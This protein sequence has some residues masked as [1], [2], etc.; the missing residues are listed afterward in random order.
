MKSTYEWFRCCRAGHRNRRR[1]VIGGAAGRIHGKTP[2]LVFATPLAA[3]ATLGNVGTPGACQPE[4]PA[5]GSH[6]SG[7]APYQSLKSKQPMLSGHF[8]VLKQ[9]ST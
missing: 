4:S 5:L 2:L 6:S 7:N 8:P 9:L 1:L 3:L